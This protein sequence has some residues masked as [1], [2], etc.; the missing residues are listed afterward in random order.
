MLAPTLLLR[1]DWGALLGHGSGR[2]QDRHGCDM[3]PRSESLDRNV[4]R[5]TDILR[6]VVE[7]FVRAACFGVIAG[8]A[9]LVFGYALTNGLCCADDAS[10]AVAA[11]NLAEGVGY[12]SSVAYFG[13]S[14]VSLFDAPISTGPTLVLPAA[15]LIRLVGNTPWAP[16]VAAATVSFAVLFVLLLVLRRTFGTTRALVFVSVFLTLSYAAS[17]GPSFVQW[18]GL[19]GEIP[20]ALL[21][22]L[23][24]VLLARAQ[25]SARLA[26][27]A[28]V[29]LGAA[30]DAKTLAILA[31][32]PV[33]VLFAARCLARRRT[34]PGRWFTRPLL[35][36]VGYALPLVIFELWKLVVLGWQGYQEN[37]KQW[38]HFFRFASAGSQ[39]V[40][41]RSLS[42]NLQL[43]AEAFGFST[44]TL[45]IIV[46]VVM[47]VTLLGRS[48]W[49]RIFQDDPSFLVVS[50]AAAA[51]VNLGWYLTAGPD[52]ARYALIGVSC[53]LAAVASVV[54]I[55][56]HR[57]VRALIVVSAV[58]VLC[59]SLERLVAPVRVLSAG[60]LH[61]TERLTNLR[62]AAA[63]L[64][65]HRG[66][67]RFVGSWWASVVDLEYM[68]PTTFNF[69]LS[70][71][72]GPGDERGRLLVRNRYWSDLAISPSFRAL[73]KECAQTVF[74]EHPFLISQCPTG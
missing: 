11:K 70:S 56:R 66:P 19:L 24:T 4:S 3:A 7:W 13:P 54:L 28:G 49:R 17:A 14:Q 48:G 10:I 41:A 38:W 62:A 58:F 47:G 2:G 42:R 50:L 20:A 12:A 36:S 22:I 65:Q 8:F 16:G 33:A 37:V 5:T 29:L 30:M 26:V 68:L 45:V 31:G 73:E 46:A 43:F 35:V 60:G 18:Y 39:S 9:T 59:G 71:D 55:A 21:T 34:S 64:E 6:V 74:N 63:Y 27:V 69:D 15:L 51:A 53:A 23:A 44:K 61:E 25:V 52:N 32:V 40:T 57:L 67:Q 72:L 1:S